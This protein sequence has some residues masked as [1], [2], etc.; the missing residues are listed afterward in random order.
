MGLAEEVQ[1]VD[2]EFAPCQS[3]LSKLFE[4]KE[5]SEPEINI[6]LTLTLRSD[7]NI[8]ASNKHTTIQG[9]TTI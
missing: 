4:S 9:L 7:K 2:F 5:S 3:F 6:T 1:R 8:I